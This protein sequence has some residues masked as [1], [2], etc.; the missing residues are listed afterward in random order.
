MVE[1]RGFSLCGLYC[2][3]YFV[4]LISKMVK[5]GVQLMSDMKQCG[6]VTCLRSVR[7]S[8]CVCL[9]GGSGGMLSK[10]V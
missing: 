8:V 4:I 9:G 5:Q 10:S 3:I 6:L 7:W 2:S 1:I